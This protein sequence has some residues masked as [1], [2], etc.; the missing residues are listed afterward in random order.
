MQDGESSLAVEEF[1]SE[2][3]AECSSEP[4]RLLLWQALISLLSWVWQALGTGCTGP[5]C[6]MWPR[7]ALLAMLARAHVPHGHV[8]GAVELLHSLWA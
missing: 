6:L 8:V 4:V 1:L 7:H 5:S 3:V 2:W